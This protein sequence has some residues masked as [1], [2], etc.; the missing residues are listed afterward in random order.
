MH[1]M[2]TNMNGFRWFLKIFVSDVLWMKVAL[3][4][5][6]LNELFTK[7]AVHEFIHYIKGMI[8]GP[9]K[10]QNRK[11]SFQTYMSLLLEHFKRLVGKERYG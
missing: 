8:L 6:G 10:F 3:A 2:N 7:F 4:L 9:A 11:Y 1:L 5:E